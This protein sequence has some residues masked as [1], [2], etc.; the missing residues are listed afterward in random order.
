MSHVPQLRHDPISGRTVIVAPGRGERPHD[1]QQLALERVAQ[2]CPFCRGHEGATPPALAT[3]RDAGR[4]GNP[5]RTADGENDD[6][7]V[8]VIPNKYPA[9]ASMEAG[10]GPLPADEQDAAA[11]VASIL[12]PAPRAARGAHEV[13]VESA[14]HVTC[15]SRLDEREAV[16]A[17]RAYRDRMRFHAQNK[18]L[19]YA[20]LFKN[21]GHDAG[22]SVE[23][24]HSQLMALPFVPRDVERELAGAER[25]FRQVRRCIF[26]ELIDRERS[27]AVRLVGQSERFV[28]FCPYAGRFP[29]E[30]WILPR[31]HEPRFDALDDAAQPELGPLLRMVV[32]GITGAGG[33]PAYNYFLHTAPF[34]TVRPDH[35][36][37]H[38][39][40]F[41]RISEVGGYEWATG[42]F[43]NSVP[44][45][46]AAAAIR[47]C[48]NISDWKS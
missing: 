14:R 36:H 40:M 20:Q 18:S 5:H 21:T 8:R 25:L 35:Y 31:R 45:E 28:A 23:H 39:E 16:A 32:G 47:R 9:L 33:K 46:E 19:R 34:D 44:P 37:W 12:S 38:I 3:Y 7:L 15:F 43:I 26:C 22:A 1:F 48:A 2:P 30:A 4:D 42:C 11:D 24:V 13:I 41:P 10:V 6:W 29:Y 17:V 27:A